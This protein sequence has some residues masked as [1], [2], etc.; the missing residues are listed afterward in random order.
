M[1]SRRALL[2]CLIVSLVAAIGCQPKNSKKTGISRSRIRGAIDSVNTPGASGSKTTWGSIYMISGS[3]SQNTF[4]NEL[5]YFT[6]PQL[7][8]APA[9]EQLGYVDG[10]NAQKATGVRFWG[11]AKVENNKIDASKTELHI[12]IYDDRVGMPSEEGGTRPA[13][14]IHIAPTIQGFVGI[15]GSANEIVFQD[16]LGQ[17]KL[18][19]SIQGDRFIGTISYT[20]SLTGLNKYR[21]L[22]TFNVLKSGF[23]E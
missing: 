1:N 23:F 19:G 8:S 5:Y 13:I 9:S 11:H 7:V 22:G 17:I 18:S 3:Q 14:S 10:A 4:W 12:D 2:L 6:Y 21:S 16:Q 15:S 20:N